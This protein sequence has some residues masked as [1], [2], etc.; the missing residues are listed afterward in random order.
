MGLGF[1]KECKVS[2]IFLIINLLGDERRI[3]R[4]AASIN[5]LL[6]DRIIYGIYKLHLELPSDL[7]LENFRKLGISRNSEYQENITKISKRCRV[8]AYSQVSHPI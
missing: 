1:C 6:L 5:I 2:L 8:V 3:P 4:N 7:K